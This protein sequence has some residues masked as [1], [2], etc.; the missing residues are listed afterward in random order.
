MKLLLEA[1]C[2]HRL[3]HACLRGPMRASGVGS[4]CGFLGAA[5]L[6]NPVPSRVG[7][8][9]LQTSPTHTRCQANESVRTWNDA[10]LVLDGARAGLSAAV[11]VLRTSA[12]QAAIVRPAIAG[13]PGWC[14]VRSWQHG[15]RRYLRRREPR[16]SS[17]SSKRVKELERELKRKDNV[18]G[19]TR[20]PAT[21]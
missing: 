17:E 12:A 2:L 10:W 5:T 3:Q 4:P 18:M 7:P 6:G 1:C 19:R 16:V 13:A 21:R 15:S 11:D 9:F 20:C 8:T 14:G